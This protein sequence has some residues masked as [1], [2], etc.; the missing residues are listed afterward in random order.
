MIEYVV[1]VLR[2]SKLR[3]MDK[4]DTCLKKE[5]SI[6]ELGV[7]CREQP[8]DFFIKYLADTLEY[9]EKNGVPSK[10]MAG[11]LKE[12]EEKNEEQ[13]NEIERLNREMMDVFD[14]LSYIDKMKTEIQIENERLKID[15]QELRRER[16]RAA[17][18]EV[19]KISR[20]RC[21]CVRE[22][23]GVYLAIP[24]FPMKCAECKKEL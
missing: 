21:E 17:R 24:T 22:P 5:V 12:L 9:L 14:R 3:E 16:E 8:K 20:G 15:N 13:K 1:T 19:E 11:V 18:P 6:C 4:Y 7:I 10:Q 23:N 2:K